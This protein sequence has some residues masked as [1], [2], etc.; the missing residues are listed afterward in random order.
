MATKDAT[1]KHVYEDPKTGFRSAVATLK[2][3]RAVDKSIA[4]EDVAKFFQGLRVK[5]E[6]PDRR[7]N[8]FAAPLAG[9]QLH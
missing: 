2:A 9:Y 8:S 1:N 4:R 3:A 7:Y 6:R 5:E